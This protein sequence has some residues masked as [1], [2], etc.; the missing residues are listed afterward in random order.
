M[1]ASAL[2]AAG[3]Q[4]GFYTSPHLS[5]YC[6]R[7]QINGVSI[8]HDRLVQMVEEIKPFVDQVEKITTFEITTA[9]GFWYY[10][11][12]NADVAVIEVG[13]GGRLD[14][15][16]VVS[17]L[18]SVITSL[19]LDHVDVLGDTLAKIATEKQGSS[20]PAGRLWFH[21]SGK[22]RNWWSHGLRQNE[23]PR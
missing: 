18:V 7:I 16:N 5:D 17:P 23:M 13:L 6:E 9:L 11:Q 15:T 2:Q 12:E 8:S 10:A 1:M 19:S 14:A 4:V 20:N 3:Y 22:K 21:R